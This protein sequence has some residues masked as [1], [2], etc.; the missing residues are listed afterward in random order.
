MV[1]GLLTAEVPHSTATAGPDKTGSLASFKAPHPI[2]T[3]PG[4]MEFKQIRLPILHSLGF[5]SVAV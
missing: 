3:W 4:L 1:H 5:N 2:T